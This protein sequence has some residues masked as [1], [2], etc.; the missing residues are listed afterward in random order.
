MRSTGEWRALAHAHT[1]VTCAL[2]QTVDRVDVEESSASRSEMMM[3]QV[4]RC[5]GGDD[6]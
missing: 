3:G 4:D 5:F 2:H 6:R 1:H